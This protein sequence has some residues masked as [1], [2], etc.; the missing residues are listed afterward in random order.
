MNPKDWIIKSAIS[1]SS[2]LY[3]PF[4]KNHHNMP[5][6]TGVDKLIESKTSF[7]SKLAFYFK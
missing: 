7:G 2:Q 3:F 4:S 5:T 1:K 6:I